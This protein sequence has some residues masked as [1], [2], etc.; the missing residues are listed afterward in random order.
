MNEKY[1]LPN[2]NVITII[3]TILNFMDKLIL[4][5]FLCLC[6]SSFSSFSQVTIKQGHRIANFKNKKDAIKFVPLKTN[7]A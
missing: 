2:A 3:V 7:V 5:I 6:E 1:Y 4:E